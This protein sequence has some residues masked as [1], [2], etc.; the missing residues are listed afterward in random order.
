V[1]G[2]DDVSEGW[3]GVFFLCFSLYRART[4][5][6]RQDSRRP[7]TLAD[8]SDSLFLRKEL[9]HKRG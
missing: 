4:F 5:L 8:A 2:L 1:A 6:D 3:D 9:Q 7:A